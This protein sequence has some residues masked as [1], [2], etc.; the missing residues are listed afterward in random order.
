ME[1]NEIVTDNVAFVEKFNNFFS[2]SVRKLAIDRELHVTKGG[3]LND[4]VS[5]IIETFKKHSSIVSINQK[6]FMPNR[7]SF[8]F[9]PENAVTNVI[10][11]IDSSKAYKKITFLQAY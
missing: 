9:V 7:F 1:E 4:S 6:Q 3:I 8:N 5:N 10:N 2:K 11:N